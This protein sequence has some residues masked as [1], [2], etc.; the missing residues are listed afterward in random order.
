MKKTE[1]LKF[2]NEYGKWLYTGSK[3]ISLTNPAFLFQKDL[4]AGKYD[5]TPEPEY[6]DLLDGFQELDK[7]WDGKRTASPDFVLRRAIMGICE[8]PE[9]YKKLICSLVI[10]SAE[11]NYN[12]KSLDYVQSATYPPG[13][14]PYQTPAAIY[15]LLSDH[16]YGQEEAKKAASMIMYNHRHGIRSNSIFVGPSGCGKSEIWRVLSS[17]FPEI[18]LFEGT[19]WS[20]SGWKGDLHWSSIFASIPKDL[21]SHAVLVCDEADK[22]MEPMYT[23]GGSDH[24]H[25]LQN[26]LLKMMDGDSLVFEHDKTDSNGER[27]FTVDCSGVSVVLL[28]AYE[29]L[30]EQ[31]TNQPRLLGFGRV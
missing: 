17:V 18:V 28:G 20:A 26:S 16:I 3:G 11:T 10:L 21:R 5:S 31:K 7:I 1:A 12:A 8:T 2:W 23:S 25:T 30:L 29:H 6:L 13:D 27:T 15:S 9:L 19:A 24:S 14:S 4:E 22:L